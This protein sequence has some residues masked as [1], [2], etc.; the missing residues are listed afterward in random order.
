MVLCF[1]IYRFRGLCLTGFFFVLQLRVIVKYFEEIVEKLKGEF[2]SLDQVCVGFCLVSCFFYYREG[3]LKRL[4]ELFFF[5][6]LYVLRE[7]EGFRQVCFFLMGVVYSFRG[8]WDVVGFCRMFGFGKR[9]YL[10]WF[11][12]WEVCEVILFFFLD[13]QL[14]QFSRR[15]FCYLFSKQI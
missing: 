2:E 14:V 7:V 5:Y 13:I 11:G 4:L 12:L 15:Y 3:L 10:Q 8:V 6:G 9:W 1:Q